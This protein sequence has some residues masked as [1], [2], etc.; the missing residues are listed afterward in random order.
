M[1]LSA[2]L[3]ALRKKW[4]VV[5]IVTVIGVGA[6]AGFAW[7][8]PTKYAS[9]VTFFVDTTKATGTGNNYYNDDLW[10]QSRV[11]TYLSLLSSQRLGTLIAREPGINLTAKQI[12]GEITATTAPST[13]LITATVTDTSSQRSLKIAEAVA[14]D[15]T[16]LIGDIDPQVTLEQVAQPT[17]DPS[18]VSKKG[19]YMLLGF[20][21]GLV[22]GIIIAVLWELLNTSIRRPDE[23][24]ELTG[25][26]PLGR[27]RK[28]TG[29]T[30][31]ASDG[32]KSAYAE[33]FRQLRTN[34]QFLS[35]ERSLAAVMV[36]APV[37]GEGSSTVA[38]NLAIA[39]AGT[40]QRVLLIEADLRRPSVA[41]LLKIPRTAGLSDVLLD[42]LP[43]GAAITVWKPADLNVLLSG[44]IPPNPSELLGSPAM[45][46]LIEECK[47]DFD[48]LIF[49]APPVLP[50]ADAAVLARH[51]DGVLMVVRYA[52]TRRQQLTDA[53]AAMRAVDGRVLGPVMT[54]TTGERHY[55]RYGA[56]TSETTN[57][58]LPIP[59]GSGRSALVSPD[60]S[61]PLSAATNSSDSAHP[62]HRLVKHGPE[63]TASPAV[64]VEEN[65]QSVE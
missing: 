38:T 61:V 7:R 41:E 48:V 64:A 55:R 39:L 50:V 28:V 13:V 3:R 26:A 25:L 14:K 56:R 4:W 47:R 15:F 63:V 1:E 45:S 42:R 31:L 53:M 35:L 16:V 65:S 51:A 62:S 18:P 19:L 21:S 29:E 12:T 54:M 6:A 37:G 2:Y 9:S 34:I 23:L 11:N 30:V 43:L 46:R 33:D 27:T 57:A 44:S 20:V 32:D 59:A 22:L 5:L 58:L 10:A 49:D 60:G 40:A 36:T 17:L 52:K 24:H 8:T